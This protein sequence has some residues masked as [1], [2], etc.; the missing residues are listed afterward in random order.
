MHGELGEERNDFSAFCV[1]LDSRF[2]G[3]DNRNTVMM[4]LTVASKENLSQADEDPMDRSCKTTRG[5]EQGTFHHACY[6]HPPP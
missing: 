4:A 6:C 2:G 3:H 1:V 5:M